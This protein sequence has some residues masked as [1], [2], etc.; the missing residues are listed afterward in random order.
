MALYVEA[1]LNEEDTG[2][3]ADVSCPPSSSTEGQAA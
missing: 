3:P 2:T 1:A